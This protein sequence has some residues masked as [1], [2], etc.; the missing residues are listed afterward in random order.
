MDYAADYDQNLSP[1][2][3][4]VISSIIIILMPKINNHLDHDNRNIV[5]LH[6]LWLS[7]LHSF[8]VKILCKIQRVRKEVNEIC[9]KAVNINIYH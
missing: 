1:D 9:C 5:N 2:Y 6:C 7:H 3:N 4:V 8:P